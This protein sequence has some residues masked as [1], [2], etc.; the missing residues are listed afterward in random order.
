MEEG[1][2]MMKVTWKKLGVSATVLSVAA[3]GLVLNLPSLDAA[4]NIPRPG[5]Y[6]PCAGW[7]THPLRM[8]NGLIIDSTTEGG[9]GVEVGTHFQTTDGRHGAD[10]II[11]ELRSS[12]QVDGLGFVEIGLDARSAGKSSVVANQRGTDYPAT[13]TMRFFPTVTV[14]G[15]AYRALDAANLVNTAVTSTPPAVGTV[16]VLTNS[17]RLEDPAKPGAVAMTIE[18]SKA[19]TVTGHDFK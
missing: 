9:I 11:R 4:V 18:P 10:L 1:E 19:F 15:T 5:T 12:G 16:Y 17:V 3:L 6:N 13:Q 14:D 8:A 7:K 2:G